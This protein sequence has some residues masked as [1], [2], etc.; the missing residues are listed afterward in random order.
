MVPGI[1]NV[2]MAAWEIILVALIGCNKQ[3][4]SVTSMMAHDGDVGVVSMFLRCGGDAGDAPAVGRISH[5]EISTDTT[6][7]VTYCQNQPT[8]FND[9]EAA[10]H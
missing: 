7:S 10:A 6:L 5:H 4:R 9:I 2:E 1:W 3:Q 8:Q